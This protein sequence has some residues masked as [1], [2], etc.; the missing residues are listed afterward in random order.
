V[1][2]ESHNN[3]YSKLTISNS[4]NNSLKRQG[5]ES[6]V[7]PAP[8]FCSSPVR[9]ATVRKSF[10]LPHGVSISS[11]ANNNN[12]NNGTYA[13]TYGSNGIY[14]NIG[15]DVSSRESIY[16]T[17]VAKDNRIYGAIAHNSNSAESTPRDNRDAMSHSM[18][19]GISSTGSIRRSV[20]VINNY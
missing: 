14:G 8:P 10:T 4:R 3:T 5:R 7:V 1:A 11:C 15:K 9:F 13:N 6:A 19:N 17:T 2:K 18:T 12:V 16:G 20:I